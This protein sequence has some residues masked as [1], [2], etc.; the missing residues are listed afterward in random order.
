[1]PMDGRRPTLANWT[2]DE[3]VMLPVRKALVGVG[4]GN[5]DFGWIGSP[6]LSARVFRFASGGATE[7]HGWSAMESSDNGI[8]KAMMSVCGGL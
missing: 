7:E 5:P 8:D 1:M 3:P 2:I 6:A 4:A